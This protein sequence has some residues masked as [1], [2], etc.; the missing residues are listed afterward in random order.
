MAGSGSQIKWGISCV[1]D[2]DIQELKRC[3][4]LAVYI[5]H[6][7]PEKGQVVPTP[8]PAQE[9]ELEKLKDELEKAK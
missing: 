8:R 4:Y 5:V 1:S 2:G 9:K 7:A 6:R 3:G